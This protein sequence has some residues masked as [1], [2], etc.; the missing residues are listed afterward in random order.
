MQWNFS[1]KILKSSVILS[2]GKSVLMFR[3]WKRKSK[4]SIDVKAAVSQ[5][6]NSNTLLKLPV[7]AGRMEEMFDTV[8]TLL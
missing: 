1:S 8:L 3:A 7:K 4:Y 2:E 5:M 6:M